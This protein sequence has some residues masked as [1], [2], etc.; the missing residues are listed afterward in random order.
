MGAKEFIEQ[1]AFTFMTISHQLPKVE[2]IAILEGLKLV[3]DQGFRKVELECDNAMLIEFIR[4]VKSRHIQ[5]DA[6]KVADCIAK[7]NGGVMDQLIIFEDSSRYVRN[8]LEEDIR[9]SLLITD[10]LH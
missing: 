6:N 2:A 1:C 4:N 3:W 10:R 5:K 8:L 9:Q 7:A